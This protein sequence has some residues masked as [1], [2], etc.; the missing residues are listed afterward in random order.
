MSIAPAFRTRLEKAAAD[1]GFD[2][3]LPPEGDWIGF[4]SSHAPLRVWLTVLGDALLLAAV[5]Q[6]NVARVLADHG[7]P[8]V[9]PLPAGACEARGVTDFASLH[10]LLR[11]AFLLSRTL[12]DELW[13][14]FAEKAAGLPRSTE[15]ERLV[16]ARIGQDVFRK[17]LL[18]YGEGRCVISGLAVPELLRA[19]HIKPWADCDRDTERLDVFN[20]LLLSANLDAAF[21]GGFISVKDDGTVLVSGAL[22]ADARGLLGLDRPVKVRGIAEGHRQYLAWHRAEVFKR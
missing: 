14:T 4:A 15:A 18:D 19:S 22:D 11:R 20:G 13:K 12:P 6:P 9:N 16:V 21:D 1:N 10:R 17:G 8:F 2:L 5:S 7:V 3:D